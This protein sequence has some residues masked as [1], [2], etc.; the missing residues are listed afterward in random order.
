VTE[1]ILTAEHLVRRFGGGR[2]W[3]GA[4]R[5]VFL[6]VDDVGFE[7][8]RGTTLGIVGESGSGKSTVARM[9]TGLLPPSSGRILLEGR[10]IAGRTAAERRRFHRTVQLVFQD[11]VSALNPRKT[12]RQIL[13]GPLEALTELDRKRRERRVEELM[14]LV[15]LRAAF[16]DRFPHEF[17][18][19]QAQR[20]AIA[21]ALAA[22]P[23]VVVLDEAVSALDVSIQAQVLKLLRELQDRLGLAYVFI[24]HDLAV[25]EAMAQEVLVMQ[26]GRIV[27]RGERGRLFRHPEHPYTRELLAAVPVPGRRRR[28]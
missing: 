3:T 21:R 7:V 17:S 18:G 14:D 13:S 27:E 9:L 2:R 1:A 25:V 11:P 20:V 6:A 12:V 28:G 24:S 8:R 26:E 5:P 23:P 19:G 10:P 15:G 16:V 22:E 4:R